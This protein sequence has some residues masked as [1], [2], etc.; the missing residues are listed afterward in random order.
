M[1]KG[2]CEGEFSRGWDWVYLEMAR[3]THDDSDGEA[4]MVVNASN[5]EIDRE[6]ELV[7]GVV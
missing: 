3:C 5:Q 7:A 6:D 4:S 2:L 1:G